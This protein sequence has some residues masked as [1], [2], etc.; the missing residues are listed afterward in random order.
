[1]GCF[2][3]LQREKYILNETLQQT[4]SIC[5]IK[6]CNTE[7]TSKPSKRFSYDI[8]YR[9]EV[10]CRYTNICNTHYHRLRRSKEVGY[11]KLRD[12]WTEAE[13]EEQIDNDAP[14]TE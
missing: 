9:K 3:S 13:L 4:S 11:D 7:L 12:L 5:R 6:G 1:M 2:R 14:I 8:K 10:L